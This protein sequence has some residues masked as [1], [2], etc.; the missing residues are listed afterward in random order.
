MGISFY[1]AL[2]LKRRLPDIIESFDVEVALERFES[3]DPI[4][5]RDRFAVAVETDLSASAN[6]STDRDCGYSLAFNAEVYA[7]GVSVYMTVFAMSVGAGTM[8]LLGF[9]NGVLD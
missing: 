3:E 7:S 1:R 6:E 4:S 2:H 9:E 8:C 5:G